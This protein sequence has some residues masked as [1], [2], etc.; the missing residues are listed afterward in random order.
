MSLNAVQKEIFF[1]ALLMT[2][3]TV[4]LVVDIEIEMAVKAKNS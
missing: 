4:Y 2:A 3:P 1:F